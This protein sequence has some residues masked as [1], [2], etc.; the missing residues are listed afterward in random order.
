LPICSVS[1]EEYLKV[2]HEI[3]AKLLAG[4]HIGPDEDPFEE[5]RSELG[6]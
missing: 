1:D 2:C 6:A 5:M 3:P 4:G